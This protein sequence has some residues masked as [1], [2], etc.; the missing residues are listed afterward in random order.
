MRSPAHLKA[1]LNDLAQ[2]YHAEAQ[3][4]GAIED[5]EQ[6]AD[7]YRKY[8]SYFPGEPDTAN[9]NFLLAEILFESDNYAEAM[10]EYERT[11]YAYPM[12]EKSAEAGYAALLAYQR[13]T[14][15]CPGG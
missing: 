12:H 2:Y 11:A 9:T 8:L 7:W 13:S 1:N 4:N 15:N 5:Y 14:R 10:T 6:A 3:A